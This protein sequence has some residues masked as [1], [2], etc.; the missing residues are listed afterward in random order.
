MAQKVM[1]LRLQPHAKRV[2]GIDHVNIPPVQATKPG[3]SVAGSFPWLSRK[4]AGRA[5]TMRAFVRQLPVRCHLHVG[6]RDVQLY[7]PRYAYRGCTVSH[8]LAH[9]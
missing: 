2:D 5:S 6:K 3:A 4:W 7:G 9:F 1:I 8:T